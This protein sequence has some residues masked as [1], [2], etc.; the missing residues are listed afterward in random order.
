MPANSSKNTI[1]RQW[2]LLKHLP[3]RPPGLSSAQIQK[4]LL[5][6]GYSVSKRTVERDLNELSL[7]FPLQCID[8][9]PPWGWYWSPGA[10]LELPGIELSEALSL[11]LLENTLHAMLPVGLRRGLEPRFKQARRKLESLAGEN[12]TA[13]WMDKV[14]SV[15][16]QMSLKAPEIDESLLETIQLGLLE[17]RQLH[18]HY[19]AAHLN[20]DRELTLNP[21][22][23]VLRGA[24]T[25]LIATAEPYSD[26]RQYALHR[27]Q[28]VDILQS[29]VKDRDQFDLQRYLD[30]D[31]LQFNPKGK[32]LLQAWI[33]NALARLIRETP[34]SSDMALE[35]V[36]DGYR[37]S[38][39]VND[40][41]QLRWWLLEQGE[42]IA[43]IAPGQLRTFVR[44]TLQ[45]AL[46]RYTE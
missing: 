43:V 40:S 24:V 30:S 7:L 37:L 25:Y 34:L 33:S 38:T 46:S 12:A 15:Q 9:S 14:A 41:W 13:R 26:V 10:S 6:N 36:E 20:K 8:R 31:A 27:F 44:D 21:L 2:E 18:C 17:E 42:N 45:R 5:D 1:S 11:V 3:T 19:Y 39:T 16:P 29:P 4:Q 35:A 22:A 28:Q 32:I 23:L